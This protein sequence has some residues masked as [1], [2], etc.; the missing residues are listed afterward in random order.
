MLQVDLAY[1]EFAIDRQVFLYGDI[2]LKCCVAFRGQFV[3]ERSLAS[4]FQIAADDS[5]P[6]GRDRFSRQILHIFDIAL[7]IHFDTAFD[8]GLGVF[9]IPSNTAGPIIGGFDSIFTILNFLVDLLIQCRIRCNAISDLRVNLMIQ[10]RI[11]CNAIS[12]L[13]V[14]LLTQLRI[15]RFQS[16]NIGLCC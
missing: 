12:G 2:F 6:F 11:G 10:C 3:S 4:D 16:T 15:F 7:V 1:I 5:I 8:G 13:R 14:D 9:Q